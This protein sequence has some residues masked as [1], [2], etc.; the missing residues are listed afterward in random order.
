MVFFLRKTIIFQG[1]QVRPTFSSGGVQLLLVG[2][3][4][5]FLLKPIELMNF[6]GGG[7]GPPVLP[8]SGSEHALTL[9]LIHLLKSS[10]DV[11]NKNVIFLFL[12]Q[13]ICCGHSK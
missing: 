2:S 9:L 3:N 1:S 5:S 12:N 4:C 7:G 8:P 6:R 10:D 11:H 13:K